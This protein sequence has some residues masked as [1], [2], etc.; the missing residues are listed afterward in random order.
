MRL[1][2]QGDIEVGWFAGGVGRAGLHLTLVVK[3]T[4]CLRPDS[5]CGPAPELELVSG[6][7]VVDDEGKQVLKYPSDFVP[8][9][10]RAD[11]VLV[12]AAH[13]PGGQPATHLEVA[14]RVGQLRKAVHVLG[15]RFWKRRLPLWNVVSP[16]KE[17]KVMPIDFARA[18][19]GRRFK[20]NPIGMGFHQKRLPNIESA[21]RVIRRRWNRPPPA[22]FGPIAAEWEPRQ[23]KVGT[24]RGKWRKER[25]P[26]FPDDF[27]WSY[28]NV[29]PDDQQ[30]EG[31][32]HGDE[33]LELQNL[34]PEHPV[35]RSQLPGLRA[36]GFVQVEVSG[37]EPEFRE[38][39]LN[40]DTLW[41][42]MEAGKVILVWRGLTPVRSVK[43]K[44]VTHVAALTEPLAA[45]MRSIAEMRAWMERRILEQAGKGPPTPEQEVAAATE[46]AAADA[47][48]KALAA[49]DMEMAKL[50]QEF[51]DHEKAEEE[52]LARHKSQWIAEGK[53]P[54]LLDHSSSPQTV[55]EF[56]AALASQIARLAETDPQMAAKLSDSDKDL[57]EAQKAEQEFAA[58]KAEWPAPLTAEDVK[59]SVSQGKP[60]VKT[61]LSGLDLSDLDFSGADFSGANFSRANL[62]RTKLTGAQLTGADFSGTNL[63]AADLSR[64]ILVG[65]DLS[66]AKVDG[67]KFANAAIEEASF[68]GL[69]MPGVDFSGCTGRHPNFSECN[70]EGANFAGAKL[71]Q[72]DFC[73]AKVLRAN[74]GQAEL[75][76]ADLGGAA[77]IG[78]NMEQA[79]LTNLRAGEQADFTEARFREAKAPKSIWE[80]A[81]LD[82]ADFSRA[83]LQRALFEDASVKD[84]NFDRTDLTK[85][86]FE[87]A[88]A[89][90]ALMT[91]A[92]LLRVSFN[93]ADLTEASLAG[94]NAYEASFWETVFKNTNLQGTN[95]KRTSLA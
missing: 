19:G 45:D 51:A 20:R 37:A 71:P 91:N 63:G 78:V 16:A 42:D 7:A 21:T 69:Q 83:V 92:N 17:F 56:Q 27:D 81:L 75:P 33:D 24:Y 65:A 67:A 84:A 46:K 62:S 39:K 85:A 35:Y 48:A 77:A 2:T 66:K 89:D 70:L 9:K 88:A 90:R 36:R 82:R 15:D 14:L 87:G 94:S 5:V 6:D 55:T 25:W 74:F 3:G 76:S 73:H 68:T 8:F 38:V 72:A 43:F 18:F 40:L 41:I 50:E 11:I 79:D 61:D 22:G 32:L 58:L 47:D 31:Y 29:A 53:D 64:A 95:L 60:L 12:G 26:W 34:H 93:R 49:L 13:A 10:P 30:V 4:Y 57:S 54:G 44:E 23:S 1:A 59:M 52:R 86:S 28:F 80:G